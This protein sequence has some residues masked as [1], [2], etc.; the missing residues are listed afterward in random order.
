MAKDIKINWNTSLMYGDIN[1]KGGDLEIDNG[2]TT[3]VII[4][5]FTDRKANED[6]PL[7]DSNNLN[8]RGWWGDKVFEYAEDDRIGS[9][10]WLL[11][12]EKTAID[13]ISK[14]KI[15]TEEALQWLIDDEI[16]SNIDVTVER[17]GEIGNEILAIGIK[18]YK[19]DGRTIPLNYAIQWDSM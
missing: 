12:R 7:P 2:L 13:V 8:K 19:T 4:S 14:A 5:L 11:E 16:A 9:R 18:I 6:D 17:Q 10:L 15:Y 3:A 1:A